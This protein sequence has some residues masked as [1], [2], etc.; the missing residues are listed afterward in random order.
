MGTE[1]SPY[2]GVDPVKECI[3]QSF[4]NDVSLGNLIHIPVTVFEA[5]ASQSVPNANTKTIFSQ[6]NICVFRLQYCER[7]KN[8]VPIN[9]ELEKKIEDEFRDFKEEMEQQRLRG[10]ME[11][12]FRNVKAHSEYKRKKH[13]FDPSF[14]NFV[15]TEL[16][17]LV[18][19]LKWKKPP[20][21]HNRDDIVNL[22][23][24]NLP[25]VLLDKVRRQFDEVSNQMYDFNLINVKD[26]NWENGPTVTHFNRIA[27]F[28]RLYH[29]ISG[30]HD[31]FVDK[32]EDEMLGNMELLSTCIYGFDILPVGHFMQ[33]Y[34]YK[35][36][37]PKLNQSRVSDTQRL[38]LEYI[39]KTLAVFQSEAPLLF[40]FI[41]KYLYDNR[42]ANAQRLDFL[43]RLQRMQQESIKEEADKHRVCAKYVDISALERMITNL[44][45]T[46]VGAGGGVDDDN[47]VILDDHFASDRRWSHQRDQSPT[48]TELQMLRALEDVAINPD[49]TGGGIVGRGVS[50][51][52]LTPD[53]QNTQQ[54]QTAIQ[55]PSTSRG[56]NR[57]SNGA[58][59]YTVLTDQQREGQDTV[60]TDSQSLLSPVHQQH[61]ITPSPRQQ[62]PPPS[63]RRSDHPTETE[64][65]SNLFGTNLASTLSNM[66]I[67]CQEG[68]SDTPS[69]SNPFAVQSLNKNRTRQQTTTQSNRVQPSSSQST[70]PILRSNGTGSINTQQT[71]PGRQMFRLKSPVFKGPSG[72]TGRVSI[73][74]QHLVHESIPRNN[75]RP[76]PRTREE[77]RR[78]E[79]PPERTDQV[80][81]SSVYNN[82]LSWVS[83]PYT[84]TEIPSTSLSSESIPTYSSTQTPSIQTN[85]SSNQTSIVNTRNRPSLFDAV[86]TD[87]LEPPLPLNDSDDSNLLSYSAQEADK[88]VNNIL[89]QMKNTKN[90]LKEYRQEEQR[91]AA[92]QTR[93]EVQL[94]TS[95]SEELPHVNLFLPESHNGNRPVTNP[96]DPNFVENPP[97]SSIQPSSRRS[98]QQP[99]PFPVT[100][101]R[102]LP[103]R[104]QLSPKPRSRGFRDY[105]R[106]G[107]LLTGGRVYHTDGSTSTTDDSSD[108]SWS[109]ESRRSKRKPGSRS[110]AATRP[111]RSFSADD[112]PNRSKVATR[113]SP[114]STAAPSGASTSKQSTTDI[115]V[116]S[117]MGSLSLGSP[118][119]KTKA[120]SSSLQAR[121]QPSE[122]Y[123][124]PSRNVSSSSIDIL[125]RSESINSRMSPSDAFQSGPPSLNLPTSTPNE[126]QQTPQAATSTTETSSNN[127]KKPKF[128]MRDAQKMFRNVNGKSKLPPMKSSWFSSGDE[129]GLECLRQPPQ[130][131]RPS[132]SSNSGSGQDKKISVNLQTVLSGNSASQQARECLDNVINHTGES[133]RYA[134]RRQ[135]AAPAGGVSSYVPVPKPNGTTAYYTV[136]R[137]SS[138]QDR[139]TARPRPRQSDVP[140]GNLVDIS[141]SSTKHKTLF[142]SNS[143]SNVRGGTLSRQG[144]SNNVFAPQQRTS[145]GSNVQQSNVAPPRPIF[146]AS[147]ESRPQTSLS[148]STTTTTI[149][150]TTSNIQVQSVT[151][152]ETGSVTTPSGVKTSSNQSVIAPTSVIPTGSSE[153]TSTSVVDTVERPVDDAKSQRPDQTTDDDPLR[154]L[155]SQLDGSSITD[156]SQ[157]TQQATTTEPSQVQQP[158][159]QSVNGI[160]SVT[161]TVSKPASSTASKIKSN[162]GTAGGTSASKTKP[163]I[164]QEK[165]AVTT[166]KGG[167]ATG[168]KTRRGSS[169]TVTET[170][171]KEVQTT[172]QTSRPSSDVKTTR[173][174]TTAGQFVDSSTQILNAN[175]VKIDGANIH[176]EERA[177]VFAPHVS[178]SQTSIP[179]TRETRQT[180][181]IPPATQQHPSTQTT[182]IFTAPITCPVPTTQDPNHQTSVS[183]AGLQHILPG[184]EHIFLSPVDDGQSQNQRNA[185]TTHHPP[186]A[187]ALQNVLPG[188]EHIFLPPQD[189]IAHQQPP[190]ARVF[191]EHIATHSTEELRSFTQHLRQQISDVMG[192]DG[193]SQMDIPRDPE[194]E[195]MMISSGEST[196]PTPGPMELGSTPTN[197]MDTS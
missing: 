160:T 99:L 77:P 88:R 86:S 197:F 42:N 13:F 176:I 143:L 163:P 71:R 117:G 180:S 106:G 2:I 68:V 54:P 74:T 125:S 110:T 14:F 123:S 96:F 178:S 29:I 177:S 148:L 6:F 172:K 157:T 149:P 10:P 175:L 20:S 100:Q 49:Q 116:L 131:R 5:T 135:S 103:Q 48:A 127:M 181:L 108:N 94:P 16:Y 114:H 95:Q 23:L 36:L 81:R 59:S 67:V 142:R 35:N 30:K 187:S 24:I 47:I 139:A 32:M 56:G 168:D 89:R 156:S 7:L 104:P 185:S 84:N 196:G 136:Q 44:N 75:I 124:L 161:K 46:N 85:S 8:L 55:I 165:K 43:G 34:L 72:D 192:H 91:I 169:S 145:T 144:S 80:P 3:I 25:P 92:D 18:H 184:A 60:P 70:Q 76:A 52:A 132:T 66:N 4:L 51:V 62:P 118:V 50:N 105:R 134:L 64:R 57:A 9:P 164:S 191:A 171:P 63:S 12:I 159:S 130:S 19:E 73:N 167:T 150:S 146:T 69:T 138:S 133:S 129:E 151:T 58:V 102:Q 79:A 195:S 113:K 188:A 194:I 193:Q 147:P 158:V 121:T 41:Q 37:G 137:R 31:A 33:R 141:S 179:Q 153:T 101:T 65:M 40:Q 126:T 189:D 39:R 15:N 83:R 182:N 183:Q 119:Q 61:P 98:V 128:F 115:S 166:K 152:I 38:P 17:N 90:F 21:R 174:S 154:N 122:S 45:D 186:S 93:T 162:A 173:S 111:S 22:N 97:H 107:P 190:Q 120:R 82:P 26:V 27:Y 78:I 1:R 53:M 155:I 28:T 109:D 87:S 170:K 140:V 11:L 112:G